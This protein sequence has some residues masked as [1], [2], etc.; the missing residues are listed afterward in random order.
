MTVTKQANDMKSSPGLQTPTSAKHHQLNR[1]LSKTF[2]MVN[3]ADPTIV[4][5]APNGD[6]FLIKN[7]DM[8]SEVILP[9]YFK[10][11]KFS[12][13]VRQLNFYGFRKIR[14]DCSMLNQDE[15]VRFYHEYFQADKPDLLHKIHRATKSADT[16]SPAQ[17]ENLQ[18]ELEILKDRLDFITRETD[19]K[20][21]KLKT[22][23]ELDYQRRIA[24]LETAYNELLTLVLQDRLRA[25]T[26]PGNG[27]PVEG[28]RALSQHMNPLLA[29][30]GNSLH[31]MMGPE[32]LLKATPNAFGSMLW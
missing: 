13:F 21:V 12:S 22:S 18:E 27:L 2:H 1:F 11:S 5:W 32:P 31:N 28:M 4:A 8:F 14:P 26:L 29:L 17:V 10:H 6:S 15:E 30:S 23:L 25:P 3:N 9:S 24:T 7:V 19:E 20:L 16:T